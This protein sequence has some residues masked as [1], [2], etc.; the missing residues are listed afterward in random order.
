MEETRVD[1]AI[2]T[3]AEG[4]I[5]ACPFCEITLDSAAKEKGVEGAF[6]VMD[7]I[8]LVRQLT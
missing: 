4:V 6:K 1:E 2:E 7:L 8:E 5:S 3:R